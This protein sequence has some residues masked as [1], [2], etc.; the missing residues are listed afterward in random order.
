MGCAA[1][2]DRNGGRDHIFLISH[3]EGP[4]WAP[5]E[6]RPSIILSHWG[7]KA[8]PGPTRMRKTEH[9]R[10]LLLLLCSAWLRGWILLCAFSCMQ[11]LCARVAGLPAAGL[12]A[13]QAGHA[14]GCMLH[15]TLTLCACRA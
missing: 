1:R 2:W 6:I 9:P 11:A 15:V 5:A 3:D 4:C 8:R 14:P 13:H 10:L 7:R 12:H